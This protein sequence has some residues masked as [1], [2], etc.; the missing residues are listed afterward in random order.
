MIQE[1]P[2]DHAQLKEAVAAEYGV[3]TVSLTFIPKGFAAVAY[4][5]TCT[6]GVTYFLKI[7]PES[8]GHVADPAQNR[9]GL[10]LARALYDRRLLPHVSYPLVN[11]MGELHSAFADGAF[12]LFPFIDGVE[13]D[14]KAV[15]EFWAAF[16]KALAAL[17]RATPALTDVLP[18]RETFDLSGLDAALHQTL[19]LSRTAY[20]SA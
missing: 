10:R 6:L 3:R 9:T 16:A 11:R 19:T 2:L 12:A 7:W 18:P 4:R 13:P 1:P 20:A 8:S 15:P 5:L 14:F 17:H